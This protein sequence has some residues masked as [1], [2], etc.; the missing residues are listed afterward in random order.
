MEMPIWAMIT[1]GIAL[2]TA[3][4]IIT[5]GSE[6]IFRSGTHLENIIKSDSPKDSAIMLPHITNSQ[7][8]M[9]IEKCYEQSSGKKLE[10]HVCFSVTLDTPTKIKKS[11]IA[12]MVNLPPDK[13]FIYE[14]TT[15]SFSIIW[16]N[17]QNRVEVRT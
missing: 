11:E 14:G 9:L 8:A 12:P 10:K 2:L 6:W 13:F 17:K 16:N 5:F 15:S 4:M 7:I 1:L 3:S